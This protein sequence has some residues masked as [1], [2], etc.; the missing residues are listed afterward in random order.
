VFNLLFDNLERK[1][2]E[3]LLKCH[4]LDFRS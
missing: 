1:L 2:Q 3:K 4:S